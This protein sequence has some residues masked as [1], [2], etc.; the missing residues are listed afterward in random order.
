MTLDAIDNGASLA[1]LYGI[2][3]NHIAAWLLSRGHGELLALTPDELRKQMPAPM[4]RA[5][6]EEQDK[7][8]RW[9]KKRGVCGYKMLF[10]PSGWACYQHAETKR[11][12]LGMVLQPAP[13]LIDRGEGIETMKRWSLDDLMALADKTVDA[14]YA[15]RERGQRAEWRYVVR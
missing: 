6:R 11:Q 2:A 4:C 13:Q 12:P 5:Q 8:F 7:K 15:P 3:N 9:H 14:V 10:R 1:G